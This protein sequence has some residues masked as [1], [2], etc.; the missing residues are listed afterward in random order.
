MSELNYPTHPVTPNLDM[1]ERPLKNPMKPG[2]YTVQMILYRM[3][4]SDPFDKTKFT[5]DE[6]FRSNPVEVEIV[7][8]Q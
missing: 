5:Y 4:A 2:K 8:M 7:A 6:L 1:G 3:F